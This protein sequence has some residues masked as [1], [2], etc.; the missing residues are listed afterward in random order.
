MRTVLAASALAAT[1]GVAVA[2]EP[3]VPDAAAHTAYWAK[4]E[5]SYARTPRAVLKIDDA[6]YLK[7]GE[8]AGV[9]LKDDGRPHA[10]FTVNRTEGAAL[11]VAYQGGDA[12]VVREGQET[13]FTLD[14]TEHA[15]VADGIE[16][17]IQEVDIAPGE[18][19]LRATLYNQNH[20]KAAGFKGLAVYDFDPA[21]VVQA[22]FEAEAQPEKVTF[23]TSRGWF[24]DFTRVGHAVFALESQEVRLPLYAG[25][26]VPAEITELSAFIRDSTTGTETYGVGRYLDV[27]VAGYPPATLTLNFNELY[28]PL[29]ARSPHFNCPV[30]TDTLPMAMRA[31]EKAPPPGEGL[32]H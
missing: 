18:R 16:L 15:P 10:V 1:L 19:G 7:A 25:S 11:T 22:R 17:R 27:A 4:A 13:R 9:V 21:A 31:G 24:K 8:T 26:T 2:A 3:A 14:A 23:A 20:P 29:C 32:G 28:N 6:V 5:E 12:I 30:A